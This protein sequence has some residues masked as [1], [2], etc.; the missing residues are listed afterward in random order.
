MASSVLLS[1]ANGGKRRN[2]HSLND[3]LTVFL[4]GGEVKHFGI[5]V[6]RKETWIYIRGWQCKQRHLRLGKLQENQYFEPWVFVIYFCTCWFS[7]IHSMLNYQYISYQTKMLSFCSQLYR[8]LCVCITAW[9]F[10]G[11]Y[12]FLTQ[13]KIRPR[14][15]HFTNSVQRVYMRNDIFQGFLL[16]FMSKDYRSRKPHSKFNFQRLS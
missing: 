12:S 10:S 1:V 4:W 6:W 7:L 8:P 13:S 9:F 16:A 5:T 3:W 15:L 11:P 2:W 14:L